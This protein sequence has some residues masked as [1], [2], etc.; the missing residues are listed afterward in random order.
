LV[1]NNRLFAEALPS[2]KSGGAAMNSLKWGGVK[3]DKH[4][5]KLICLCS[6]MLHLLPPFRYG[7]TLSGQEGGIIVELKYSLFYTRGHS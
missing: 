3:A 4:S 6:A 1:K 7:H 5:L 2:R